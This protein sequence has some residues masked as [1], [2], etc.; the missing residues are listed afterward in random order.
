L[1]ALATVGVGALVYHYGLKARAGQIQ[2]PGDGGRGT[3]VR[4]L[5][6]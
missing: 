2:G 1:S 6:S 5:Q 3:D 4:R